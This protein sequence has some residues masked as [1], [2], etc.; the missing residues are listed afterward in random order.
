MARMGWLCASSVALYLST[1]LIERDIFRNGIEPWTSVLDPQ[2]APDPQ[3]L[4]AQLLAYIAVTLL[5]FACYLRILKMCRAGELDAGWQRRLALGTPVLINVLLLLTAPRMSQ[6]AYSYLAH[7]YLGVLP[8]NNPLV[9]GAEAIRGNLIGIR[10]T[11]YGWHTSPGI[12]PYGI[13]WTRIEVA[14]A[15]H[16]AGNVWLAIEE[17]KL[18]AV[19]SNL[20]TAAAIWAA[21]RYL[22]PRWQL[23]GTLMYVWNPLALVEFAAEGHNDAVMVFFTIAALVASVAVRPARSLLYQ[24]LGTLCKYVS[25]LFV[26]AQLVYL[27]RRRGTRLLLPALSAAVIL[28]TLAAI[29]Y[30]PFWVGL[31]SFRG[32]LHRDIPNGLASLFGALGVLLRRTPLAPVS[33]PLRL[34]VLTVP[35][36]LLILW[37]SVRVRN[38]Q[39]LARAWMWSSLAF[40]YVASPDFW[41]W[42]A[43]MPIAL[44]C[45]AAPRRL[46]W[47]VVLVSLSGRLMAPAEMVHDHGYL[48]L[49]ASKALITGFASLLPLIIFAVWQWYQWRMQR[50]GRSGVSSALL[51]GRPCHEEPL[52]RPRGAQIHG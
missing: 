36:V 45:V 11:H 20:A 9:Q 29:L 18:I 5:I 28:L 46:L 4:V 39:Q 52:E 49:K 51:I 41:P 47:V 34:A 23:Y 40:V 38:G 37:L 2:H 33:G 25:L 26:P 22:R 6:D 30:V 15:R 27:W 13:L 48:G 24:G 10:I 14:I 44:I 35:T 3:L 19:A 12:T 42:Y 32:L 16:C 8:G 21:L 1:W 50:Q 17:F 7:G 31:G 43:C